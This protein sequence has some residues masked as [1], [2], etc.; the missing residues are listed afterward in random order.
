[1]SSVSDSITGATT[2]KGAQ[3]VNKAGIGALLF[4][5]AQMTSTAILMKDTQS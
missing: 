2:L 3:E 1:M 5:G 4:G